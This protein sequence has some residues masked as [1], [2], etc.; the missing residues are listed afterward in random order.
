MTEQELRKLISAFESEH[1]ERTRAFDK[2]NKE[3]E[4]NGNPKA[5]F[6]VN[7]L[8]EFRVTVM[9]R[10][11]SGQIKWSDKQKSGQMK[12]ESVQKKLGNDVNGDKC[13]LLEDESGQ[14]K[15]PDKQKSG[16]IKSVKAYDTEGQNS[17]VLEI[18]RNKPGIKMDAIFLEIRTSTRSVRRVLERLSK[19]NRIEYRGSKRTGGWFVKT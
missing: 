11:E 13:G 10:G 5:Q 8:T 19:D 18:I 12:G 1:V 15:W 17:A 14:I 4:R 7:K 9:P 6:D 2:A 3:L 16:Q